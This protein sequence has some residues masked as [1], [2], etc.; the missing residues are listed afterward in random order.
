M[1]TFEEVSD[2]LSS[3]SSATPKQQTNLD[4]MDQSTVV[5]VSNTETPSFTSLIAEPV[6]EP[7][8][9]N[10][11]EIILSNSNDNIKH[12]HHENSHVSKTDSNWNSVNTSS[13]QHL[14]VN[15]SKLHF[16]KNSVHLVFMYHS[17][18]LNMKT[19]TILL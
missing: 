13:S 5:S 12:L 10:T 6:T 19:C 1:D 14:T 4:L 8:S 3:T 7:F 16:L 18:M 15:T 17:K 9:L 2:W 11:A